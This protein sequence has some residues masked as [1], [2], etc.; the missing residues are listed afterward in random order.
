[1]NRQVGVL[2]TTLASTNMQRALR[3]AS[4]VP[5]TR[6]CEVRWWIIPRRWRVQYH[7][8][9]RANGIMP[10]ILRSGRVGVYAG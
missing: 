3:R 1:M 2:R 8:H 6:D 9:D 7:P 10:P 4:A 5:L